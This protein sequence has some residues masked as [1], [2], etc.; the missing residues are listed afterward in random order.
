MAAQ[1][2]RLFSVF[3]PSLQ[4]YV[5]GHSILAQRGYWLVAYS[6]PLVMV[7][8]IFIVMLV[9][10][11]RHKHHLTEHT[12]RLLFWFAAGMAAVSALAL[13]VLVL[14]FWYPLAWGRMILNGLNPYYHTMPLE[15]IQDLPL[16]DDK[17]TVKMMY[18]PLWA[19]GYSAVM[20]VAGQQLWPGAILF[21]LLFLAAWLGC[22]QLIRLILAGQPVWRQS[23]G[24]LVFGW[25]PLGFQ[26]G[27]AEGHNDLLM[28]FFLL[29]WLYGLH[30][31]NG[32]AA[33]V[34]LAASVLIKYATLPLFLLDFLYHHYVLRRPFKRYLAQLGWAGGLM[35]I[36]I[37]LFYRSPEF[38][39]Y[40]FQAKSWH[41]F[42]PKEVIVALEVLT[43]WKL[44]LTSA[45]RTIFGWIGLYFVYR[46][47]R[48]P[49][50][51]SF[52]AA[53]LGVMSTLLFSV[54]A[55]IWPWYL[56]WVLGAAALLPAAGLAR[57]AIGVALAMPFVMLM[58]LV[59]PEKSSTVTFYIPV[60]L[61]Y[62]FAA[63][64]FSISSKIVTS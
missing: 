23:A 27:V 56:L 64:W 55:H 47:W 2:G 57:W 3:G 38:F 34:A 59:F 61:L 22:L 45:T 6:A 18:G 42:S 7:S 49:T 8:V 28:V 10:L 35:L 46:Y 60:L 39:I 20:A 17:E 51:D 52:Y 32:T 29:L 15:F 19:V 44:Y 43:G 26:Q 5:T 33:T 37:A 36:V 21:K 40:L 4:A 50:P 54:T 53:V 24:L 62:L 58:W 14:D 30:Q 63:V 13:P 1:I 16:G 31:K 12:P 9:L 11:V 48:R 25:L 41:F